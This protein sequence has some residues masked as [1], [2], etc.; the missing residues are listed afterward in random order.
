MK[1]RYLCVSVQDFL[2][3]SVYEHTGTKG[4]VTVADLIDLDG[5]MDCLML[6]L[7]NCEI[8]VSLCLSAGF[9]CLFSI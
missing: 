2:A 7:S 9:S 1:L 5:N 8:K 4:S 6:P 3:C